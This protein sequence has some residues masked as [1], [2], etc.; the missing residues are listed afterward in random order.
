MQKG[1][2][3]A[4]TADFVRTLK[5]VDF[6]YKFR[7]ARRAMVMMQEVLVPN[8]R[9]ANDAHLEVVRGTA[10]KRLV[11]RGRGFLSRHV[12]AVWGSASA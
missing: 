7:V 3:S 2:F 4:R 6:L 1:K 11:G 8:I 5:K 9:Q 12:C 10:E